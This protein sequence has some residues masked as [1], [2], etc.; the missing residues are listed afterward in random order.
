[1]STGI[2]VAVFPSRDVLLKALD[3]VT[4]L[5]ELDILRVAIVAKAKS[6]ELVL[7]GDDISPDEGGVAGSALGAAL[8][9]FGLVQLGAFA[10]P[11]VGPVIALGTG[12]LIG[13]LIGRQTG[14]FAAT[15]VDFGFRKEQIKDLALQLQ[16]G[17]PA[18][19]LE[20]Q[21]F[22]DALNTLRTKLKP[23]RAELV[24]PL[25]RAKT[26]Q[27]SIPAELSDQQ[28]AESDAELSVS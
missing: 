6:G 19:I 10:L 18:L 11:G 27:L 17:H 20:V 24:E 8:T 7:L 13:G 26:G 16:E 3:E 14:R 9:V 25:Y 5:T 4:Q 1:V 12:A 15:M 23:F 2:I 21:S 28:S 22:T